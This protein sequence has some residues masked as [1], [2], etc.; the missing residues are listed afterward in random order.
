[1]SRPNIQIGDEVREMTDTEFALYQTQQ[2]ENARLEEEQEAR[3]VAR[4]AVLK[5]LKLSEEEVALLL[6]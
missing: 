5:K 6:G 2:A 4:A 1:M 3:K